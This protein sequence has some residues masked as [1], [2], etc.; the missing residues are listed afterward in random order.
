MKLKFETT[1][2]EKSI[3]YIIFAIILII[4]NAIMM[5]YSSEPLDKIIPNTLKPI[6]GIFMLCVWMFSS[7]AILK[8]Y[9]KW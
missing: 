5:W 2:K 1:E 6:C 4:I 7:I 8:N 3:L 9:I